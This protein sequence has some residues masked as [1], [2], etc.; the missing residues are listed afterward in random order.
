M[1]PSKNFVWKR[2][3]LAASL[4][5]GA[6]G[7]AAF[8][9]SC[10][11]A[12][13]PDAAALAQIQAA[14]PSKPAA[15]PLRPRRVLVY[16]RSNGFTHSSRETGAAAMKILG[17]KTGAWNAT[18]SDDPSAFEDLSPYDAVIF[19][20]TTGDA[21]LPQGFDK[22]ADAAKTT[23]RANE[24]RFKANL[25]NFVN[26]GKGFVGIHSA[27]DTYW[28]GGGAW[29]SYRQ[30]IGGSFLRH[31]WGSGDDVTVR[32]E[33][34]SSPITA[35]LNGSELS[36][37]EE[38]YMFQDPYSRRNQ[39]VILGLD[40]DK[41]QRRNGADRVDNDYAVS[42]IKTQGAGRV[43]YCS[44]GHNEAMYANPQVLGVYLAGIQY[45]LGDLKAD[46][47]PIAQMPAEYNDVALGEY[48]G[49]I[50][51]MTN[52]PRVLARVF[53]QGNNEYHAVLYWPDTTK[54]Y[55]N[56]LERAL[57]GHRVEMTGTLNAA[58]NS[59]DFSGKDGDAEV[60]ATWH[61]STQLIGSTRRPSGVLELTKPS[62]NMD[63]RD[64]L[65][66][67]QLGK[68]ERTSPTLLAA[69]PRGAIALIPYAADA[70]S[71]EAGPSMSE[72]KNQDWIPMRDGSVQA[73][74]GDN[75][76]K[77]EFG[78]MKLHVEWLT[79]LKP[80][81]RGQERGNS[82]VY[83]QERYEVQVLD[84]FGLDEQDNDA[85]GLYK[86][87]K[88]LV[89]AELPPGQWQTYDITYR[90]PRLY[91]DGSVKTLGHV[92]I[93][94]N[95]VTIQDNLEIPH[96]T[97]GGAEGFVARGPIKLQYHGNPVRFRNVWVQELNDQPYTPVAN[98]NAA[99]KTA[100]AS[101]PVGAGVERVLF[102][103]K[104]LDG[105]GWGDG[106][107]APAIEDGAMAIHGGGD[108]WTTDQ[109]GN[110]VLDMDWKVA[111]GTNSGVFIRNPKPGDWYSGME[112]Q[113][114]DSFG[115]N[116]PDIHDAGA[117]YDVMAPSKNMV[118]P[119]G[120]W[121]TM[122]ITAKDQNIVVEMNGEKVLDQNLNLWAQ[123]GKN[124]DGTPNKFKTAYKDMP[125]L[126]HIEL[127]D[128]DGG[129]VWY[130]NIKLRELK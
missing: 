73:N 22:L 46:A 29:D 74:G 90:A 34:P 57:N 84:S 1:K 122:R 12:A 67:L 82:G 83:L 76:S 111:P 89:N 43:F 100:A 61:A 87:A 38:I 10:A 30:M 7:A 8:F 104:S 44:L 108:V 97:G 86:T 52:P 24:T 126:G 48:S 124:P 59:I 85:G 16:T 94:F 68:F 26:S 31:P 66:N 9:A 41:T 118:K 49:G 121:N 14:A 40:M 39:R 63:V 64:L 101:A 17:Q 106:K 109:F 95:G 19:L 13:P 54:P 71:R 88:P 112:I 55:R 32:S 11:Q 20:N 119:A 103:G 99:T 15:R 81:A 75:V 21:L 50:A 78:D 3:L 23:A 28:Q 93:A 27:A 96:P 128:H 127:Q 77:R 4:C 51:G 65:G 80:E 33:D 42:W 58:A 69:P 37:K 129:R 125:R 79:P 116:P 70:R 18:L 56:N 117:N 123:A 53:P 72:W 45:A 92:T 5:T 47:T 102:D 115:H 114:L 105:W 62:P 60:K 36:F 6:L 107:P 35:P 113:I 25:L 130:R 120:Q 91:T 2:P 98:P 110:F